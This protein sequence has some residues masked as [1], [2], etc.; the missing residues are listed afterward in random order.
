MN[1]DHVAV[2]QILVG[3]VV[4]VLCCKEVIIDLLVREGNLEG[5][6]HI[7]KFIG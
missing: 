7:K 4:V 5:E 2:K 6:M 3:V 1:K